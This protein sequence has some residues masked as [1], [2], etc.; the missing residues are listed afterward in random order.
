VTE[1]T[2]PRLP[3]RFENPRACPVCFGVWL[4]DTD[5]LGRVH[6]R[7]PPKKCVPPVYAPDDE[8]DRNSIVGKGS[9]RFRDC[10]SCGRT[11]EVPHRKYGQKCCS[12]ECIN[13]RDGTRNRDNQAVKQRQKE[14]MQRYYER[15]RDKFL[16]EVAAWQ[17][18]NPDKCRAK[19]R[20]YYERRKAAA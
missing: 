7:H 17:K 15:N 12:L 14:R 1:K 13:R 2:E 20:R 11:F 9:G 19:N 5:H 8:S 18:A 10:E 4:F 3:Q 6:H 16:A